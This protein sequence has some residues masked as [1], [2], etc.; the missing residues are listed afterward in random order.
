ME[1]KRLMDDGLIQN[2]AHFQLVHPMSEKQE[3]ISTPKYYAMVRNVGGPD[4]F[5]DVCKVSR[6][7]FIYLKNIFSLWNIFM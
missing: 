5:H 6:F 1:V 3:M 2:I 4:I 7:L